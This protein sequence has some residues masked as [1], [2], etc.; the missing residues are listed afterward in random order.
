VNS[1]YKLECGCVVD[2]RTDRLEQFC[3]PHGAEYDE[4]HARWAADH[5][6]ERGQP[7]AAQR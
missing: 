4:V 1:T 7:Q 2:R 5:A 3:K 6:R